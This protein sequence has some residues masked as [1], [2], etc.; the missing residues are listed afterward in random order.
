MRT[1]ALITLGDYG[2]EGRCALPAILQ[3]LSDNN[4]DVREYATNAL[5][6]IAPEVLTNAAAQ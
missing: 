1:M 5:Q 2:H 3:S 4:E 6:A